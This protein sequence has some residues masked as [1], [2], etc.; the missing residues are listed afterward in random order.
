MTP[1]KTLTL[2]LILHVETRAAIMVSQDGDQRLGVW[3]PLSSVRVEPS[4]IDRGVMVTLPDWL[5]REKGLLTVAAE[6]QG[7]LL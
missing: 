3:L 4:E 6:G 2:P 1:A 7:R 5:A